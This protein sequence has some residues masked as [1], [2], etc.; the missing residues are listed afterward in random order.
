MDNIKLLRKVSPITYFI[1]RVFYCLQYLSIAN[2]AFGTRTKIHNK[3]ANK[4]D[5]EFAAASKKR[6]RQ[7]DY[8]VIVFIFLELISL[9]IVSSTSTFINLLAVII[10]IYRAIDI[11]QSVVNMNIFDQ[12]RVTASRGHKTATTER[13]LVLSVVNFIELAF[14]FSV[15]YYFTNIIPA[16]SPSKFDALYFSV[17]VQIGIGFSE[18]Q[19]KGNL[20]FI[21]LIHFLYGFFYTLL[22]ISRLVGLIPIF[23]SVF[24]NK[25]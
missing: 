23:K 10:V 11:F 12:L 9:S 1:E 13:A 24:N 17:I 19:V 15:L 25:E 22:I 21:L 5:E 2:L 20:K 4:S 7:I 8:Y 18:L 14:C 6:S 16:D 3:Y